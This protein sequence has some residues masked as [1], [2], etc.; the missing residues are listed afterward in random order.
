MSVLNPASSH[1]GCGLLFPSGWGPKESCQGRGL[2][3]P[4]G[5]GRGGSYWGWG[6]PFLS[7]PGSGSSCQRRGPP[8]PVRTRVS[9]PPNPQFLSQPAPGPP[10]SCHNPPQ[11]LSGPDPPPLSAS[12]QAPRR[13]STREGRDKHSTHPAAVPL[14]ALGFITAGRRGHV[15]RRRPTGGRGQRRAPPQPPLARPRGGRGV[16]TGAE[17]AWLKGG[18]GVAAARARRARESRAQPGGVG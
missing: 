9:E 5:S 13:R 12:P 3:F 15:R 6:L 2:P 16:A 4:S 10:N 11:F 17:G 7:D 8:I 18:G 1:W 14:L